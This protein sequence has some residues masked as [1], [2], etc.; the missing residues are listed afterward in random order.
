[1]F[2]SNYIYISTEKVILNR[3]VVA[4]GIYEISKWKYLI[5]GGN[6]TM[7][8]EASMLLLRWFSPHLFDCKSLSWKIIA[9][10]IISS[11]CKPKP[12]N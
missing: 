6:W 11:V 4:R 10:R 3:L 2:I 8:D 1:M 5:F 12:T 7:V 9:I